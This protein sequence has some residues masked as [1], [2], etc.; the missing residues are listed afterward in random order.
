MKNSD[1]DE[2]HCEGP[3]D[4]TSGEAFVVEHVGQAFPGL[5]VSGMSVCATFGGPRMG[6]M[7]GGMLLSGKRVANLIATALADSSE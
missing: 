5:W 2:T 7:F 6:P 1:A 3:M 4:A